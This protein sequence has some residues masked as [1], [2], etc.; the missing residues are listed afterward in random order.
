MAT[1]TFIGLDGFKHGWVA[2]SIDNSG[3]NTIEFLC[4]V[5]QLADRKFDMAMID[6]PIGLPPSGNRDCDVE[7]RNLLAH[8]RSRIFT[9]ARRPLL[10]CTCYEQANKLGKGELGGG[11]S[12]QLY[13]LLPK[14]REVDEFISKKSQNK[15]R[16]THPELVFWR[17]NNEKPLAKKKSTQGR[18]QRIKLLKDWGIK[19]VR[20]LLANRYGT[21]AKVDDVLDA[22]ACAIAAKDAANGT[23][24]Y[25]PTSA[26]K[27]DATGLKMQIWY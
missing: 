17:L 1:S 12:C 20:E 16:E 23:D 8:H 13:C 24:C 27:P 18:E 9:G 21:G 15:M 26:S 6:I 3:S 2:V 22:C 14:I 11:V 7:A 19:D 10:G 4:D 25:V 5:R